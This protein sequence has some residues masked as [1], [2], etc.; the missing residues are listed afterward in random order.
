[1]DPE[2]LI[3]TPLTGKPSTWPL[4]ARDVTWTRML[5]GCL[6]P[7][8]LLHPFVSYLSTRFLHRESFRC[9]ILIFIQHS[10]LTGN[11]MSVSDEKDDHLLGYWVVHFQNSAQ[12]SFFAGQKSSSNLEFTHL[13]CIIRFC[14]VLVLG[15]VRDKEFS[16]NLETPTKIRTMVWVFQGLNLFIQMGF[17]FKKMCTISILN[18]FY[19]KKFR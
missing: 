18:L 5:I 1:M 3:L 2:F 15:W 17:L 14:N 10:D 7:Y 9:Q 16:K 8:R 4:C 19:T 13:F 6:F 11:T 12:V